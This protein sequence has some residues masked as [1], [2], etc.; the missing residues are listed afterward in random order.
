MLRILG[1]G[2]FVRAR[3]VSNAI[4]RACL[5]AAP[6]IAAAVT[7][8]AATSVASAAAAMPD[9]AFRGAERL[10]ILCSV[11]ARR[12]PKHQAIARDLCERIVR[13]AGPASPVAI[14]IVD[15]GSP[16]LTAAG[17]VALLVQASVSP[18]SAAVPGAV[19]Q[20]IGITMRTLAP[21]PFAAAPAWFGAAPRLAAFDEVSDE[22]ANAD[23][24]A[25]LTASLQ[26]V[27]PWLRPAPTQPT[28]RMTRGYQ[29]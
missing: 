28:E 2:A 14:E 7:P 12:Q 10:V 9:P 13:I 19:G 15:Y 11:D 23:L 24:D 25:V 16:S 26:D 8:A 21:G 22:A 18:A 4:F 6:L 27:L 5:L 20:I 1:K 29:Q 3:T 17:S